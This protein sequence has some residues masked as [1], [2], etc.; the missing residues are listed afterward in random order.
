MA[1]AKPDY[2][3]S[4]GVPRDASAEDIKKAYRKLA[5][6]YHPDRNPGD[7]KAEE[8]F[9]IVTEAYEVLGDPERRS[10]YDQYGH[11]AFGPGSRGGGF[12][13]IDLEEALR[14]FMGA[15]GS[16]GS[17]FDNFFGGGRPEMPG[18]GADL[19]FDLEIDFEEAAFGSERQI[20]IPIEE[21]CSACAGSGAEPGSQKE[22]CGRC[23]GRG[24]LISNGGFLQFRQTCPTCGGSGQILRTP[25]RACRGAGR[26]RVR[27]ALSL[28]I[29]VGVETG[30]RLR[31]VG[32]GEG[33]TLG[34][35]P[36]DL[37]V[38]LHVR[39]HPLFQRRD[40]DTICEVPIP[41]HIAALGG[42]IQVPTLHGMMSLK[43][44]A[45]TAS[46]TV[47]RMRG[48]GMASHRGRRG[49]DHHV[50]VVIEVPV[51]LAGAQRDLLR[52]L[53]ETTGEE[54]YPVG[55]KLRRLAEDFFTRKET[56]QKT[57]RRHG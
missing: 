27:R 25:C 2:Y 51:R 16:G 45:G 12:H 24:V 31:L 4:L 22:T 7:V 10:L 53:G 29:P 9:K 35:P 3:E 18:R 49:G 36:G 34:G 17:I 21:D 1:A 28:K 39:P 30:S 32:K 43:V 37:Y 15:F 33:G 11:R 6:Q 47:L 40:E 8:H 20:E 46:G 19:R 42:D 54:Q 38:V 41:F 55:R 50:R 52:K 26:T 5:L 48:K 23:G 56:M 57:E 44:P 13:G 14:T